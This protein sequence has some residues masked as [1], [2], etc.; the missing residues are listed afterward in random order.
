M[1]K[2]F[3]KNGRNIEVDMK[4][5]NFSKSLR[6]SIK[7][8]NRVLLSMPKYYSFKRA[9]SFVFENFSKILKH[10][11][12]NRHHQSIRLIDK[13]MNYLENKERARDLIAKILDIYSHYYGFKYSGFSIR[14]QSTR[15]GSCSNK[16]HLNFNYKLLFLPLRLAE[17]VVV[18][19]LCHLKEMNHSDKFW[20][21][22]A[23]IFPNYKELREE[24]K[25]F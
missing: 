18:H 12:D 16:G 2:V 24:I 14:N 3:Q 13:D 4:K 19:E 15:W 7:N 25:K 10:L 22:V 8:D 23:R 5:C 9:E 11:L 17:Y 21:L 1:Q 20:K 6:I